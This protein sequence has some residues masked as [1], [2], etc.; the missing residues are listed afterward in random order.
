MNEN[1]T[2]NFPETEYNQIQE[3][4]Y[5]NGYCYT[6]RV[7]VEINKYEIGKTYKTPWGDYVKIDEKKRYMKL[8]DHPFYNELT[9]AQKKTIRSLSEDISKPYVVIK[10]SRGFPPAPTY[11]IE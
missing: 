8:S 9:G 3:D 2:I 5:R 11:S 7:S 6:T 4:L 1:K 10:F